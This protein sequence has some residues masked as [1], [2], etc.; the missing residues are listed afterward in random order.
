MSEG[1]SS[2]DG[3]A[4]PFLPPQE[5]DGEDEW[6]VAP[7]SETPANEPAAAAPADG[8]A[9]V[10]A[11]PSAEGAGPSGA[12]V[13]AAPSSPAEAPG[14][15]RPHPPPPAAA[16]PPPPAFAQAAP[17][18]APVAAPEPGPLPVAEASPAAA[19][20]TESE[21]SDLDRAEQ[22][23]WEAFE[24]MGQG[25][26]QGAMELLEEAVPLAPET[27]HLLAR[28]HNLLGYI[29]AELGRK[30]EA[31]V[32][33]DLAAHLWP[34]N[35][36]YLASV[37]DILYEIGDPRAALPFYDAAV[38]LE[39]NL[40]KVHLARYEVLYRLRDYPAALEAIEANLATNPRRELQHL[41]KKA[42]LL[43]RLGM[44]ERV[45]PELSRYLDDPG[46]F[47]GHTV[48]CA[49]AA[50]HQE[51]GN[52]QRAQDLYQRAVHEEEEDVWAVLGLGEVFEAK[53]DY[54]QA[55]LRFS[56]VS[57]LAPKNPV[58]WT[59]K[60]LLHYK[61]GQLP[62]AT[63]TARRAVDLAGDDPNVHFDLALILRAAGDVR[64]AIGEFGAVVAI[65]PGMADG[66]FH[67][68][69][70]Y[71]KEGRLED[72]LRFA[73]EYLALEP[74]ERDGMNRAR[75]L[76]ERLGRHDEARQY[77]AATPPPRGE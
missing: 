40:H 54:E 3:G 66:Y 8:A 28:I 39:P 67:L 76:L 73:Q 10:A 49:Q 65:D 30:G 35:P 23:F 37:G 36:N 56:E 68:S 21:E 5:G 64:G 72:A 14:L 4:R 62:E 57:R 19:A 50:L 6:I 2:E 29:L 33:Y 60:A 75:R 51:L 18:P 48:L 52:L 74:M 69:E 47:F 13:S 71:E 38:A 15:P 12:P 20:G 34:D 44:P 22:L 42:E 7:P 43:R 63:E 41:F 59:S 77:E 46:L 55:F 17:A 9:A 58:G 45:R 53:G 11:A 70:L 26:S 1:K 25:D 27:D 61:L 16:A 31:M 32:E 24:R